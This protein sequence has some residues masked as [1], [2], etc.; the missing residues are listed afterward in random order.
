MKTKFTRLLV[1]YLVFTLLFSG[2]TLAECMHEWTL[3]YDPLNNYDVVDDN[4]HKI[5]STTIYRICK[6]CGSEDCY[7]QEASE[8]FV[9]EHNFS[10]KNVCYTCGY[11]REEEVHEHEWVEEYDPE[12][13]YVSVD[14][15]YHKI[16]ST[17]LY[18]ICEECGERDVK[19]YKASE[20]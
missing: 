3:L 5:I 12:N 18:Y 16:V 9:G 17:T 8:Q 4:Y 10:N 1:V 15:D 19:E 14:N 2:V 13:N 7:D 20:Q 6:K 11:E